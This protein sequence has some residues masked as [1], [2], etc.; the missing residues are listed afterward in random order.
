MNSKNNPKKAGVKRRDF[1]VNLPLAAAALT[2]NSAFGFPVSTE[3]GGGK[4]FWKLGDVN[5]TKNSDG[6]FQFSLTDL[7]NLKSGKMESLALKV[8]IS[9]D[10]RRWQSLD[11]SI[12]DKTFM[13]QLTEIAQKA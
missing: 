6:S 7:E 11:T 2:L 1:L 13:K 3:Q 10:Q 9:Y 8:E 5:G 12:A 4:L